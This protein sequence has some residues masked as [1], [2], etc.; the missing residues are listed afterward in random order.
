MNVSDKKPLILLTVITLFLILILFKDIVIHPNSYLFDVGGDGIKNYYTAAYY[1]KYD[2]GTHFTGMNYP[3]GENVVFAATQP[4]LSFILNW[5]EKNVFNIS[6]YTIGIFNSFIIFSIL[7][8]I[9]LL[10]KILKYHFLPTWYA[11][12]VSIIIG[13]L[14]PQF[15]RFSG[16]YGLSYMLYVPLIWYLLI[17]FFHSKKPI[18]W[19]MSLSL[20]IT[21]FSFITMYYALIGGIFIIIYLLVYFL[22]N[23]KTDKL[24]YKYI[25]L[26]IISAA[27]PFII[28]RIYFF[29]T[30]PVNDRIVVPYGFFHYIAS[31]ESVFLPVYS[32]FLDV[33][34]TF[35]KVSK[36]QW[37]GYA[38][39]GFAGLLALIFSIVKIIKYIRTK[40]YYKIFKPVLPATLSTTLWASVL[41]LLI[42]MA[43]PFKLGLQEFY[44]SIPVIKQFRGIGRLSWIFYYVFTVYSAFYFYLIFR[45]L[46]IKRLKGLA[47]TIISLLLIIWSMEAYINVKVKRDFIIQYKT[48]GGFITKHDNYTSWLKETGYFP[49]DFQAILALPYFQMGSEKLYIERGGGSL[50]EACK[51][52]YNTGLPMVS[53]FMS[54]TSI[55]QSLKQAQLI[56][57][58]LIKKDILKDYK[59]DKPLLLITTN[60]TLNIAENKLVS[61]SQFIYKND[62]VNI[63]KLPL[64]A[65]KDKLAETRLFF[66]NCKDSLY[67]SKNYLSLQQTKSII[68]RNYDDKQADH[69]LFGSGALYKE[70]GEIEI[71][72]Q[73]IPLNKEKQ[74]GKF[75][76]MTLNASLWF[77]ADNQFSAFPLLKYFQYNQDNQIIEQVD[78]N[79]KFSTEIYKNWV[80][81]DH[82]FT[83]Y[84]KNNRIKF[85]IIWDHILVDEFL[86]KPL[87][88]HVFNHIDKN[89]SFVMDNYL[90]SKN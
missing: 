76:P 47:I 81:V 10:F 5:I 58:D 69:T 74:L 26:G 23:Y 21:L 32:P 80:R 33:W 64:G 46:V 89:G 49:D 8:C 59:S 68:I 36:A 55:S 37:E 77:Y 18:L 66:K 40:K 83:L 45:F 35:I 41:I 24:S 30:D 7:P 19:G 44:Y 85:L 28:I 51:A 67:K 22:Q 84:N 87:D 39:V 71:Y 63:Y 27:I 88:V 42:S 78:I 29:L 14:S 73:T 43:Y 60:E 20:T 75:D 9:L 17:K 86:I 13:F 53:G 70:N 12:I 82:I 54:R 65:F 50:F 31:F 16:H 38:Y 72:N 11:F 1:I 61:N 6:D 2:S 90:I 48:A 56:S 15:S 79:P 25:I 57:S 62:I 34:N 3:Y 4:I 52:S